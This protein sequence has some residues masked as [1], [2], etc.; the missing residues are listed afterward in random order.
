M[1]EN[2]PRITSRGIDVVL[3]DLATLGYDA[4]WCVLGAADVGAPH[5]RHRWWCLAP[6]KQA[7]IAKKKGSI[8]V[9]PK[10]LLWILI[11]LATI[12]FWYITIPGF[13][14]WY[15]CKKP[16]RREKVR[17]F[18]RKIFAMLRRQWK[19]VTPIVTVFLLIVAVRSYSAP[20]AAAITLKDQYEFT[21]KGAVITGSASV[22]CPC[23]LEVSVNGKPV[24]IENGAFSTAIDV[25]DG[26]D[27]GKV[28]VAAKVTGGAFNP[29]TIQ[30]TTES[31]FQRKRVPIEVTNMLLETGDGKYELQVRGLPGATVSVKGTDEKTVTLDGSGSG[32]IVMAFN[33]AYNAQTTKYLLTAKAEG[34]AEGAKEVEVKNLKYDEKRV[35]ADQEKEQKRLAAEAE[36]KRVQDL[37]DN[38]QYYEGNRAVK[39]A[40]NGKAIRSNCLSYSCV[41]SPKDFSYVRIGIAVKNEGG[42]VIHANPNYITIQDGNGRTYTHESETY[43]LGNYFDA[44]NLQPDSYTDGWMAFILP[45]D[46]HEFLL[47]YA[48]SDGAVAKKIYVP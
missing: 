48:S 22:H 7:T 37:I 13:A 24:T 5:Q 30:T 25:P 1:L 29:K 4:R 33:T 17:S 34:Y 28:E 14:I 11:G 10:H 36:K 26:T 44:V 31:S 9:K 19:I 20:R 46:E 43:S 3:G 23:S 2:S 12:L 40:V 21:G 15:L 8:D 32:F 6:S 45:R 35:A 47:I 41:N 39:V 27:T 38:M 18:L 16:E 42:S